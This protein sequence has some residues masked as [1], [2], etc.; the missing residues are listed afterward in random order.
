MP[1]ARPANPVIDEALVQRLL[2]AQFPAWAALPLTRLD[3][4][5][6]DN[7]IYR[8]GDDLSV[9]LPRGEWAAGQAEKESR[10][11]PRLAP[12]LPVPIPEPVALGRPGEGYPW[13]WSVS[14]WLTGSPPEIGALPRPDETAAE[15]ARFVTALHRIPADTSRAHDDPLA[16]RDSDTRAAIAATAHV[17]DSSALTAIWDAALATPPHPPVWVHGDL[18]P[19]NLLMADGRLSAVLDFGELG[20]GDPA[21]DALIAW[22]LLPPSAREVFRVESGLDD[23]SWRRGRGYALSTGLNAYTAYAATNPRVAASTGHQIAETLTG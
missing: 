17:F 8:L 18:H 15:L 9:R 10:W 13:H 20:V 5:G 14:R 22:T 23:D 3:P 6:S 2:T 11:L 16:S 7:V 4:A 12:H 21:C 1:T 19:G